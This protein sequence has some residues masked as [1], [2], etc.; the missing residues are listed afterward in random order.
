MEAGSFRKKDDAIRQPQFLAP[1]DVTAIISLYI[2]FNTRV[3]KDRVLVLIVTLQDHAHSSGL[4]AS[5]G[6]IP[7]NFYGHQH[8][9][10]WRSGNTLQAYRSYLVCGRDSKLTKK[11]QNMLTI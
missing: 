8:A 10:Q 3:A 6:I 2:F 11:R 5:V 9:R 4:L 7:R 1:A